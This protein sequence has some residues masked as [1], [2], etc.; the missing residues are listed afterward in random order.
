MQNK[1]RNHHID[2][3]LLSSVFRLTYVIL[4]ILVNQDR[5]TSMTI[6]YLRNLK[7]STKLT[8]LRRKIQI[9][10]QTQLFTCTFTLLQKRLRIRSVISVSY[11]YIT[12]LCPFNLLIRFKYYTIVENTFKQI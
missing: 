11:H 10:Y 4:Q 8:R 6:G 1:H 5:R 3:R 2:H 9:T 7:Y 12:V